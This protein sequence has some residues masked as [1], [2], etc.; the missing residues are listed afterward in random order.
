MV[1]KISMQLVF[2]LILTCFSQAQ[3]QMKFPNSHYLP[4]NWPR[5]TL[6]LSEKGTLK[7]IFDS[8]IRPYYLPNGKE[9]SQ[10]EFKHFRLS[11]QQHSG[12]LL[13]EFSVDYADIRA[14]PFGLSVLSLTGQAITLQVA[15]EEMMKWFPY[16]KKSTEELD[17]FLANV[18]AKYASF[19]DVNFSPEPHEFKVKWVAKNKEV[20]EVWLQKAY[21]EEVP[22]RMRLI[23]GWY[24]LRTPREDNTFYDGQIPTPEGYEPMQ[25]TKHHG[26]DDMSE[27]K[28][29][30]G[31][32][33]VEGRGLGGVPH[34]VIEKSQDDLSQSKSRPEKIG[35]PTERRVAHENTSSKTAK[36]PMNWIWVIG[37]F[38]VI[39]A[40]FL[41]WRLKS[42]S[43]P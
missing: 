37:I 33:F 29:A 24:K 36:S 25:E 9:Y 7:D 20:I 26:L 1:N 40:A 23:M 38:G 31:I 21:S 11:I 2:L 14:Q 19:D 13:P 27:M 41:V 8:G 16:T 10:L 15:R 18:K 12:E 6:K 30:K 34:D 28:Y 39:T 32:P 42:N 5:I 3:Y 43:T 4:E 35:S 17:A 22:L